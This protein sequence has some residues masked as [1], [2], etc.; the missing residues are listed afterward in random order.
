[1]FHNYVVQYPDSARLISIETEQTP[2]FVSSSNTDRLCYSGKHDIYF[3]QQLH[4]Q[5]AVD[6]KINTA[7]I[8][9]QWTSE[10]L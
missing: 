6:F 1:M 9:L 4:L 3:N 8:I 5:E 10:K 2:E 7:S